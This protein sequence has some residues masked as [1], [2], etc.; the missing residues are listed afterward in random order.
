M[1]F[2][3]AQP[4]VHQN[5]FTSVDPLTGRPE[6][7]SARIPGIGERVEFCPSLTG[8]R[9]WRPEAFSPQSGLLYVPG[10]VVVAFRIDCQC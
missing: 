10:N 7:D 8:G 5:V 4:F 9:Q 3:E 1:R 6:Y 2:L